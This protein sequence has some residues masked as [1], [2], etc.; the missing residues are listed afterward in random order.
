MPLPLEVVGLGRKDIRIVWDDDHEGTYG[1]RDQR[2]L[3]RCA[4]CIDEMTGVPTL[5]PETVPLDVTVAS[6]ELIGNYGLQITFSDGHGTGI[7]R[8]AEL[9]SRCPC[10]ACSAARARATKKS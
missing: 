1:T 3:C 5:D 7:Y 2:L 6:M 4:G 10:A 8:F 9:L